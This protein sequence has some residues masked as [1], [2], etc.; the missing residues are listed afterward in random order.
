MNEATAT[1][2]FP[3]M[4]GAAEGVL[5]TTLGILASEFE[6]APYG[7][8]SAFA[9]MKSFIE[10]VEKELGANPDSKLAIKAAELR[11]LVG[12]NVASILERAR[13]K[14]ARRVF[15]E[16]AQVATRVLEGI[17]MPPFSEAN[18][19]VSASLNW[20]IPS[21]ENAGY[22]QE[23]KSILNY[24]NP[25]LPALREAYK[26]RLAID[27]LP[28]DTSEIKFL[29]SQELLI[30]R[31]VGAVPATSLYGYWLALR[32][33]TEAGMSYHEAVKREIEKLPAEEWSVEIHADANLAFWAAVAETI[34]AQ[35]CDVIMCVL[36]QQ[37]TDYL[38]NRVYS[39]KENLKDRDDAWSK[40]IIN[41][42]MDILHDIRVK[43]PF[44]H[45]EIPVAW[46]LSPQAA[47]FAA[48]A[49][50]E[51]RRVLA[52]TVPAEA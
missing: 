14:K 13:E 44:I 27:G 28:D 49:A 7:V 8:M 38:K 1:N 23:Q 33:K 37:A 30:S 9:A 47:N 42:A 4:A 51:A 11:K 41:K 31:L 12:E 46:D 25:A 40:G 21:L 6:E 39:L 24:E 18:P 52:T 43:P 20:V 22:A 35:S 17:D 19:A 2:V 29:V 34:E 16:C 3:T 32:P 50:Y 26:L 10:G 36:S 48:A 15:L 45:G 5:E